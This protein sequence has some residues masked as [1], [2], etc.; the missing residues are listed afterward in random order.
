MGRSK[1]EAQWL[2]FSVILYYF[3]PYV[4]RK[5]FSLSV[6]LADSAKLAVRSRGP[7]DPLVAVPAPGLEAHTARLYTG[8]GELS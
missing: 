2:S 7:R 5:G 8:A 6:E 4:S 3:Q 1:H